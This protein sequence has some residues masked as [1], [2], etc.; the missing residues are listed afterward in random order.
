MV[1]GTLVLVLASVF[2]QNYTIEATGKS[3]LI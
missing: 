2:L 3:L 1:Q